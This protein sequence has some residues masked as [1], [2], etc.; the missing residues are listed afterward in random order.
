MTIQEVYNDPRIVMLEEDIK[1]NYLLYF[2]NDDDFMRYLFAKR[3]D[4]LNSLFEYTEENAKLLMEFNQALRQTLTDMY[5][6]TYALYDQQKKLTQGEVELS[7]T[8]FL[9]YTYIKNHP[10]Q[11]ER[12]SEVWAAISSGGFNPIYEH[13]GIMTLE[14]DANHKKESLMQLL[15]LDEQ[16]DNWNEGLPR[17]WS[18]DMGLVHGFHSVYETS[19]FSLYDL[20]YVREFSLEY[21]ITI[22]ERCQNDKTGDILGH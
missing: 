3:R 12:A 14:V 15:F 6:R 22:D 7:A 4:V 13:D 17:E 5:N 9:P 19:Y 18:K 10:V 1:D 16:E 11:T 2:S 8:C 20:L 21:K